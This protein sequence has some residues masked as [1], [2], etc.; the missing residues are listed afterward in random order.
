MSVTTPIITNA[1]A[2]VNGDNATPAFM[3]ANLNPL[4]N[5]TNAIDGFTRVTTSASPY[6]IT[7]NTEVVIYV[8]A[9]QNNKV[10]NLPAA[11]GQ[12]QSITIKKIDTTFNTVTVTSTGSD[13][14]ETSAYAIAPATTTNVISIPNESRTYSPNGTQW[15]VESRYLNNRIM[16]QAYLT[17]SQSFTGGAT[18]KIG[19]TTETFD[20]SSNYTAA[21]SRFVAPVTGYYQFGGMALLSSLSGSPFDFFFEYHKN[22]APWQHAYRLTSALAGVPGFALAETIIQL[23][24]NDF[25]ELYG[26]AGTSTTVTVFSGRRFTYWN[27]SLLLATT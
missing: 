7:A 8:D 10:V 27:G 24:A 2:V 6:N 16:F 19:M 9:S 18:A 15:R 22:G 21:S 12:L 25:V 20:L 1:A 3:N 23:N 5:F 26:T 11:T 13:T 14:V 17:A 4:K